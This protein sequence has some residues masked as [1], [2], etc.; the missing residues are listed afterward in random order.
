MNSSI[1]YVTKGDRSNPCLLLVHGLGWTT[2]TWNTVTEALSKDF[3][4]VI[5]DLPGHGQSP[6]LPDYTFE[7]AADE[8]HTVV[9]DA[10]VTNFSM[11]GSS[12]GA[13]ISL[14]YANKYRNV[15]NLFLL[16]GG[17]RP[18]QQT[19][20]LTWE[21][22]ENHTLPDGVLESQEAFIEFMRG[23]NPEL[24]NETIEAAVLDQVYWD[25]EEEKLQYKLGERDQLTYM[26]A[27]WE[28]IPADN[29]DNLP[30]RTALTIVIALN[31][32][33]DKDFS[34]RYAS[35]MAEKH[36]NTEIVV[37]EDTDHLIM[38]DKPEKLSELLKQKL[39]QKTAV[40]PQKD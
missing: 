19:E 35:K 39:L 15:S 6:K 22:I 1:H 28:F 9:M 26:K 31:E 21:D 4:L 17:Y 33:N 37:L 5:V 36:P 23:D 27:E 13:S 12:I 32:H 10:G 11:A 2:E 14:V 40:H 38:L 16:D 7:I 8:L 24:W 30:D 34:L 29:L 18:F 25:G 20:G 3:F